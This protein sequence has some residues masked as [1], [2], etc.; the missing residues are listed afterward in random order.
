MG[1]N[2]K[3]HNPNFIVLQSGIGVWLW[4]IW[5]NL[6]TLAQSFILSRHLNK[7]KENFR[8]LESTVSIIHLKVQNHWLRWLQIPNWELGPRG[9]CWH[10]QKFGQHPDEATL[11]QLNIPLLPGAPLKFCS[12]IGSSSSQSDEPSPSITFFGIFSQLY[13]CIYAKYIK[14]IIYKNRNINVYIYLHI[15]TYSS[16]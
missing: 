12:L 13:I 14:N 5:S 1:D 9:H 2:L 6:C 10:L 16:K 15:Y 7:K 4:V 11:P 8:F 3:Q